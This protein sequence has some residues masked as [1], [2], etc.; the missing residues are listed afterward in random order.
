MNRQEI[1]AILW[2]IMLISIGTL[3]FTIGAKA[4]LAHHQFITGG[5]YG[6]SLLISRQIGLMN[7]GYWYLVLNAPL[8]IVGYKYFSRRFF[9]Y[10]TYASI[11]T[12]LLLEVINLNFGIEEQL[13]AAIASGV[14]CGIGSGII[15][16]SRG[17]SGGLD[18]VALFL[19]RKWNIGIGKFF[20]AFNT[21]LFLFLAT[22]YKPD[23][24]IS[25]VILTFTS[26]MMID[27]V[28]T[29]FNQ[30]KIVYILSEK[31]EEIVEKITMDMKNGA[32][33]INIQGAYSGRKK[34]MIMTIT[35]NLQMKKLEDTVFTIDEHALF[36][37][38]NSFNVLGSNFGK[39]KMY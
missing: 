24:V 9:L 29:L 3:I 33:L 4:I 15:F 2:D 8:L 25:S 21:L 28:I 23:V 1:K 14:I 11:L 7:P 31:Y 6:A 35:N 10:N 26:S 22:Q 34:Q 19:N 12:T 32:T 39:R 17:S 30:R 37:A 13:Y 20:L 27:Q 16:R 5:M 38:E 36:I 18:I